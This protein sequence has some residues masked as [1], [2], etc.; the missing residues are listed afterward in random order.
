MC[1][2]IIYIWV[3]HQCR[4]LSVNHIGQQHLPK[5]T[6]NVFYLPN[7]CRTWRSSAPIMVPFPSLSKTRNPS[8]K[9]SNVPRSFDLDTC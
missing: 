5:E 8:T 4:H 3:N 1:Q 6:V 2:L 7:V 9:S